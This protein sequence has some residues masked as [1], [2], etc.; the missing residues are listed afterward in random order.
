[1]RFQLNKP[2]QPQLPDEDKWADE[3]SCHDCGAMPGEMHTYGCDVE[4]CPDC[5]HQLISCSCQHVGTK[6]DVDIIHGF[7]HHPFAHGGKYPRVVWTG[8]WPGKAE[9]QEFNW[10]ARRNPTGPGYVPCDIDDQGAMEDYNRLYTDDRCR[11]DPK[12]GRYV[13]D[14]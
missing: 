12:K 4:R 10:Y 6:A 11:W 9:C 14:E 5:G 13:L 8:L 7:N 2:E 1:M 3:K